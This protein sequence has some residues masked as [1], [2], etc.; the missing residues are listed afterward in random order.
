MLFTLM[1]FSFYGNVLR[2]TIEMTNPFQSLME[3]GDYQRNFRRPKPVM[4]VKN[5]NPIT[6]LPSDPST[7]EVQSSDSST[8]S[9]SNS[10]WMKKMEHK[11]SKINKRIKKVC[12][13]LPSYNSLDVKSRNQDSLEKNVN[14]HMII[15]MKHGLSYCRH[16]KV[17]NCNFLF[18][19]VL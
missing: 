11:Y 19:A 15:D 9:L 18:E 1:S 3:K 4:L 5:S 12:K 10:K 14:K 8:S 2:N 13:D 17:K 6:P 7:S 16:G